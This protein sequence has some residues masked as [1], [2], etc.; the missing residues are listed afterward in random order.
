MDIAELGLVIRSDGV[1]VAKDRLKDFEGQ[2]GRAE[3]ATDGMS[4]AVRMLTPLVAALGAAF[5]VRALVD[6]ADA[7]SDMRSRVGAAIK[8]MEAAP[9]MMER[10]VQMA[11]AS[12]SP[13]E[14][15]VEIYSRNVSVLKEL[16]VNAAG[17]A[18]FTES[19][20][21]MLVITATRGERAASVQNALAKAMAVGKLQADGLETVLANGGRVAEAL[22]A[23]LDTTVSGLRKMAS[24]GKITGAVIANALLGSLEQVREEAAEMPATIGDALTR[25]QNNMTALIGTFDQTYGISGKVAEAIMLLADNLHVLAPVVSGLA[26]AVAVALVPALWSATVAAGALAAA[27][28]ANPL[29][30][31]A[32]AVGAV[33]AGLVALVQ[34]M[35]GVEAA[36]RTAQVVALDVMGRIEAGGQALAAYMSG[37]ADKIAASF[38]AAWA[39]VLQGFIGLM[40]SIAGPGNPL[41]MGAASGWMGAMGSASSL[42]ASAAAKFGAGAALWGKATGPGPKMDSIGGGSTWDALQALAGGGGV[43]GSVATASGGSGGSGGGKRNPYEDLIRGA[44]EFIAEQHLEAQA[45]GMTTEAANRLRHEQEMLNKAANDNIKLSPAQRN[46]ISALAA[47]MAAAEE[48]TRRLT[49]AANDN[50]A[51]WSQAQDG[52]SSIIKTWARGGDILETISNKLLNIGDMLVDMA[53]RDLFGAAF[54]GGG[55]GGGGIF[56]WLG[57]L[58]GLPSFA[59]GGFTGNAPRA[60]GLD[61][62][63]GYLAMVHPQETIIDHTRPQPANQNGGQLSVRVISE[64]RGGNLVPVMTEIAG[65][66]S[67]QQIR[68][69]APV[70]VGQAVGQANKSAPAA[71]AKY[72]QQRGGADWRT[73]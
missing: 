40:N 24:E 14:Q 42:E 29:T 56:G 65:E 1:V 22:A 46:E 43:G 6:Y 57:S 44:R 5:S 66:V 26:S 60:G 7:W 33:V 72:Q 49:R 70:L 37:I 8:D 68:Q 48:A 71:V 3:R 69:T 18:D 9:R 11:N 38:H 35:G 19:L 64:V 17:A 10:L 23:E 2:A 15:T 32:L 51:I 53:V 59:G 20:N 58:L 52:V 45:L 16:G 39:N 54:G 47:E 36:F 73:M 25:V 27:L 31:V 12:Y 41:S 63:G 13:L 62:R 21:H 67:G 50:K 55:G 28:L 61:G 4:R 30:W 34:Q